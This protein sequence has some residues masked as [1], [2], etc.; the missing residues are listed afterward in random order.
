VSDLR[1]DGA[2]HWVTGTSTPC[3]SVFKPVILQDGLPDQGPVPGDK[4]DNDT[5]WWR[6]EALHRAALADYPDF[7]AGFAPARDA[8]EA[9]FFSRIEAAR[10]VRPAIRRKLV[11]DCWREAAQLEKDWMSRLHGRAT[12]RPTYRTAWM[13]YDRLAGASLL[14]TPAPQA[15]AA[16]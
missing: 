7:I 14:C 3:L 10:A 16:D 12:L 4:F 5:L 13:R 2:V 8:L 15:L 9:G 6:H 1:A 11:E